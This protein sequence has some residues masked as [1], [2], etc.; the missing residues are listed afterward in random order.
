MNI[1]GLIGV[2]RILVGH[3]LGGLSAAVEPHARGL[4]VYRMTPPHADPSCE[5]HPSM[6]LEEVFLHFLNRFESLPNP[7]SVAEAGITTDESE[8]LKQ[9][10]SEPEPRMW[11]G[12]W[13]E[14]TSQVD[15]SNGILAS[16]REMFGGL[17]LILASEVCRANS[18]EDSVWPAVTAALQTDKGF[19]SPLFVAGQPTTACKNAV[20]AG[21]CRLQLRNLID[22]YG[23][24][25]YF[26]TLK[27]Q[28]GFTHRGAVRRLPDWL[29]GLGLPIAVRI[30]TG[31]DPEYGDLRSSSFND[32]WDALYDFRR[33]RVSDEYTSA[34][35]QAS[36]WIRPEW[37]SELMRAAKLRSQ[38]PTPS[39]APEILDR[40]NEPVR[41][42]LLR[43]EYPAK[44]ELSLRLNEER[45]YEILGGLESATFAI[46]GRV[47]DRWT[48]QEGGGW[49]GRRKLPCQAE[50]A[51]HNLR[52]SLLSISSEGKLLEEVDLLEIGMGEPLLVFDL[53]TG[54]LVSLT[55]KLNPRTDYALICDSD[56]TVPDVT[57]AI[58]LKDRA[59]YRL[60]S[61]WPQD[62][63]VVCDGLTY[64]EPTLDQ[65]EPIKPI[66]LILESLPGETTQI[67]SA[68]RVNV[69]GVSEDVTVV[70]VIAGGWHIHTTKHGAIWQ[71]ERPLQITLGMA[72]GKERIR[73]Q[74]SSASFSR[75]VAPKFSLSLRG[76]ACL[77]ADS[78]ADAEPKWTLLSVGHALNRA[79]GSG[80]ARV[81]VGKDK[82]ELFEGACL[83]GKISS[84]TFQLGDLQGWGAPL[85]SRSEGHADT[86]LVE[87]VEDYGA[88]KFVPSLFGGQ[89][90]AWLTW[91]VP[92]SPSKDHRILVWPQIPQKPQDL[93]AIE[94][95]SQQGDFLWKLPNLGD[96]A[97]MAIAYQG[98][99]IASYWASEP[100]IKA[101]GHHPANSLFALLRW[102]K[103][104]VLNPLF[105]TAVEKAVAQD[106]A[107]F[108]SGWLD[109]EALQYG[110]VH[111][112]AE[113]GLDIVIRQFLWNYVERSETRMEGLART[114]PT[115]RRPQSEP[116]VFKSSLSRLGEFCPSLSYNLA[117]LKLRGDKYRKYVRAVAAS[118]LRQPETTEISQLRTRMI[119]DCRDCANLLKV[120]PEALGKSV[121]AFG[122]YL[123]NQASDYKQ[124]EPGLRRL[125]ETSRGRP[126]LT[127][128]LLIRLVERSRF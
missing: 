127:A 21:A 33:S 126:F 31:V 54:T 45:I 67:G 90:C 39:S 17:L 32:L 91:Q 13:C 120:A 14:S 94:V 113:Q 125:G 123:D 50:G 44:P 105:R 84:R 60:A 87:S 8:V 83:V 19:F 86:V 11:C 26:D 93:P 3:G 65:R 38:T 41:E 1:Q 20:T 109:G 96:A 118:M 59:A 40:T 43:W 49:R 88:G 66:R 81:F 78:N 80:R 121:D 47:V 15:L 75:T 116:E 28:F 34:L 98:T 70:T 108:V 58:K 25:E 101:L 53:E 7:R 30:L 29:D 76:I 9:W 115:D 85:I 110:L 107:E 72:L 51:K 77:E 102:L 128:S 71:T 63:R 24:Q 10:F 62:L 2:W 119:A 55:S 56:L 89:T 122:A 27:L 23:A 37:A 61:P 97:A 79:D 35:L 73:I 82:S 5:I 12:M 124:L 103:V 16:K 69:T 46:D 4:L 18:N 52:P 111:R 104:P 74:V 106:P 64:W 68:S 36:P 95:A 100:I 92:I 57:Q 112:P 117:R 22:R 42:L 99:R 48:L 114:F 6:E